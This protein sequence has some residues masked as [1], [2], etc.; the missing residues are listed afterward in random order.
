[1]ASRKIT[2]EIESPE[3]K[4]LWLIELAKMDMTQGQFLTKMI[5]KFLISKGVLKNDNK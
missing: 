4:R 3:L 5:R 2:T 1:M